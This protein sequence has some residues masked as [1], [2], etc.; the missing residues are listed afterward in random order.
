MAAPDLA[1]TLFE[2]DS[3]SSLQT[4]RGAKALVI[5]FCTA[6]ASFLPGR[7]A[8]RQD[9]RGTRRDDAVRAVPGVPDE[10]RRARRAVRREGDLRVGVPRRP[11]LRQ[12]ARRG[13]RLGAHGPRRHGR[14]DQGGRQ[15]D[16]GLQGRAL[17]RRHRHRAV[18]R[19]WRSATTRGRRRP[20]ARSQDGTTSFHGSALKV[21][22]ETLESARTPR[23]PRRRR[24]RS[25]NAPPP[26]AGPRWQGERARARQRRA[27]PGPA[28][29]LP[30]AD[31]GRRRLLRKGRAP[32]DKRG[33]R[34]VLWEWR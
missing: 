12:G 1:I 23:V 5:D 8:R 21:T 15:G 14:R 27:G 33:G 22:A 28:A 31:P 13:E 19:P 24:P 29:V 9:T 2:D 34:S 26:L 32:Q 4:L 3:A 6:A 30:G 20:R 18:R 17:P 25:E 10:A 11:G 7:E 16:L